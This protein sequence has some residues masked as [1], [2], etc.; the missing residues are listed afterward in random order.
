IIVL[1][2]L[3]SFFALR[4]F[5]TITPT[6]RGDHHAL[7]A[8]FFIFLPGQYVLVYLNWY[9]MFAVFIPVYAFLILPTLA[10][11][12]SESKDFLRR[13]AGVQWGVMICIF[14]VSHVP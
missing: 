14:C 7:V 13:C 2:Y 4:E 9:G 10:A 11:L 1:F 3:L 8:A 5:I 6:R 12:S